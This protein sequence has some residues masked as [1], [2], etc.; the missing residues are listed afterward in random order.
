MVFDFF[1]RRLG[2]V[3]CAGVLSLSP[4]AGQ[5]EPFVLQG[6]DGVYG[7]GIVGYVKNNA[8]NIS[9][10]NETSEICW[11]EG[12]ATLSSAHLASRD[13]ELVQ[14]QGG[15]LQYQRLNGGTVS[16]LNERMEVG[17]WEAHL[18]LA[19]PYVRW[20]TES[21]RSPA[22]LNGF[23][24]A[25][26]EG[27]LLTPAGFTPEPDAATYQLEMQLTGVGAPMMS[28]AYNMFLPMQG[29]LTLNGADA[30]LTLTSYFPGM[31]PDNVVMNLQLA[32]G[33][34]GIEGTGQMT[35]ENALLAGGA[36]PMW[37]TMAL[38]LEE[39]ATQFSGD[40]VAF[41]ASFVGQIVTFDGQTQPVTF[42]LVGAGKQQ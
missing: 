16:P 2:L 38:N 8:G 21:S 23:D 13:L 5:A 12:T 14:R 29:A 20:T 7:I 39:I 42:S 4:L 10:I 18:P 35:M 28:M 15:M 31:G 11:N 41:V 6:C 40:E 1:T 22:E 33:E 26:I 24:F 17:A 30:A 27:F 3:A 37:K 32:R 36:G 19:T 25:H 9:T 34:F